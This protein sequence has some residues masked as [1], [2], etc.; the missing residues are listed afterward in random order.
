M[1]YR[2][3]IEIP[4]KHLAISLKYEQKSVGRANAVTLS[5]NGDFLILN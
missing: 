5:R 1:N 3:G 4:Q 2:M